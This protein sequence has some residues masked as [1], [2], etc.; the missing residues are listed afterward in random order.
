MVN[1][2]DSN[3]DKL[4]EDSQ[5]PRRA[6]DDNGSFEQHPIPDR[7]ALDKYASTKAAAKKG[8]GLRHVRM[9]P[10]SATGE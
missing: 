9:V 8:I 4:V 7:I 2:S 5:G 3:V 10:P 1:M 6:S